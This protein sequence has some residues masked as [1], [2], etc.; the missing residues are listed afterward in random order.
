MNAQDMG[1]LSALND[2]DPLLD[3]IVELVSLG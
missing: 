3:V 2:Q 1:K